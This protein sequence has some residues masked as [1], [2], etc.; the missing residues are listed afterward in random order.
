MNSQVL[1]SGMR[2]DNYSSAAGEAANIHM[3]ALRKALEIS[4]LIKTTL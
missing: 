4:I 3:L 2:E 1:S